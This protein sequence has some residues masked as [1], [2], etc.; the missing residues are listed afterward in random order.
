[1][2][3][4]RVG[5]S[6]GGASIALG[7]QVVALLTAGC[8]ADPAKQK[9]FAFPPPFPDKV[10]V[11]GGHDRRC[12]IVREGRSISCAIR[13]LRGTASPSC[14]ALAVDVWMSPSQCSEFNRGF[15]V[16]FVINRRG[17][18]A[19]PCS[20]GAAIQRGSWQSDWFPRQRTPFTSF[21]VGTMEEQVF[22]R[23]INDH[24]DVDDADYLFLFFEDV[25]AAATFP[26]TGALTVV[27]G[28]VSVPAIEFGA[29][30]AFC[31]HVSRD[32]PAALAIFDE[33]CD[34]ASE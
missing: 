8:T 6:L 12:D 17:G 16:L 31:E 20:G 19:C 27:L 13:A 26:N 21:S 5:I 15:T 28:G 2:A 22:S 25:S 1:M 24:S 33:P 9:P 34:A 3:T 30:A 7:A 18:D 29:D 10:A 32:Y 23:P 14:L 11:L 4:F